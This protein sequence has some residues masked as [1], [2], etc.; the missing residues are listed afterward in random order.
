MSQD[1]GAIVAKYIELRDHKAK[2][3]ADHDKAAAVVTAAMAR[4][5]AH[6]LGV[7]NASGTDS[8]GTPH[9][10]V[11]KA[12][13]TSATVADK[14]AFKAFLERT[15]EWE[16]ADIRAAKANIKEYIDANED[17]PP[18]INWRSET[19]VRVNRS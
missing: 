12:T 2:L 13:T 15:G 19:V 3:K 11:F 9:G 1:I 18:G 10:T 8:M 14:E 16:L 17:L 4:I 6:L 7:L 5:D